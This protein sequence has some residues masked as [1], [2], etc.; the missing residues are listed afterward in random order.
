MASPSLLA[1]SVAA[2]VTA[3]LGRRLALASALPA[4]SVTGMAAG[5]LLVALPLTTYY[6]EDA[7][8]YGLVSMFAL[9]STYALVRGVTEPGWR[10]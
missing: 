1:M 7:R 3:A 4:P 9:I 10:W 5:L 2:A 6:V 8:P